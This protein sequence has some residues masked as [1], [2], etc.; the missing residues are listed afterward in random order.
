METRSESDIEQ[1]TEKLLQDL[2]E[3]VQDGEELL[4]A[5]A[6]DLSQRGRAAREKLAAALEVARETQRRIQER[7]VAGA[8]AADTMVREH[9][10]QAIGIAFGVGLLVGVLAS[11][12]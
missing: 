2:K 8:R 9:P 7:A 11:R 12:R 3:V 4:K 10:Y 5:G 6:E 1:S